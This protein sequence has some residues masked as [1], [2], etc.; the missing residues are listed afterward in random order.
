MILALALALALGLPGAA[1]SAEGPPLR[2]VFKDNFTLLD[3]PVPAPDARFQ[4][5][6]EAAVTLADFKGRVVLLNFWATWCPPCIREMPSLDRLQ[7]ARGAEGLSVVAVSEDR[8]GLEVVRPFFKKLGLKHLKIYLDPS[9]RLAEALALEGLPTTL[10]ID[11]R[12]RLVG[13]LQGP[14]EWDSDDSLALMEYYLNQPEPA[15][16]PAAPGG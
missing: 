6:T 1:Q 13:G 2:G 3:E 15:A 4:D 8:G 11:R 5:G 12:G 10:L 9:G 7:A 16:D 14:A